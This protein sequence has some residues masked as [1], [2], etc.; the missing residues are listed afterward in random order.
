VTL[1][2]SREALARIR[3]D[4]TTAYV[5]LT[6]M[7]AGDYTVTVYVDSSPDAGVARIDPAAIAVRITSAKN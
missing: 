7:V 4:E 2:G 5:D 3:P 1:R 6:D